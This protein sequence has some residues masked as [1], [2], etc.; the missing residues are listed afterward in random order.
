MQNHTR[1][2]RQ[3]LRL[4]DSDCNFHIYINFVYIDMLHHILYDVAV[5]T[6]GDSYITGEKFF[7]FWVVC[8]KPQSPDHYTNAFLLP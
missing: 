8:I 7:P 1:K 2:H 3:Y 6:G 4:L 5:P